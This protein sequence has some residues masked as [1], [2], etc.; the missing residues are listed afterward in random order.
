MNLG[1]R[2]SL[3]RPPE[4]NRKEE[5]A[6]KFDSG[7]AFKFDRYLEPPPGRRPDNADERAEW[8]E[9]QKLSEQA[10]LH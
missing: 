6:F 10:R 3:R 9:V 2:D 8:L 5:G 1:L 4:R 7:E